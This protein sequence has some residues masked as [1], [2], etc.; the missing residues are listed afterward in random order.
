MPAAWFVFNDYAIPAGNFHHLAGEVLRPGGKQAEDC[1][2][3]KHTG[4]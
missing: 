4:K 1:P 3:G 2:E